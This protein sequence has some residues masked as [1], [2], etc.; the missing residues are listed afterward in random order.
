[1]DS[2][3]FA[4]TYAAAKKAREE[5]AFSNLP[6]GKYTASLA[7][8]FRNVSQQGQGRAQVCLV[9]KILE[10]EEEGKEH[11]QYFG[12]ENQIS[13]E[14]LDSTLQRMGLDTEGM[15]LEVLDAILETL[16][17]KVPMVVLVLK[18]KGEYLNT[19]ISEFNGWTKSGEEEEE[20]QE[21]PRTKPPKAAAKV[22]DEPSLSE[23]ADSATADVGSKVKFKTDAGEKVGVIV[24]IDADSSVADLKMGL[25]IYKDVSCENILEIVS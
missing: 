16:K 11:R 8:A 20:V 3:S 1:M 19:N 4:A 21:A 13:L 15:S 22:E 9:W 24:K 17:A 10:G 14:I 12:L 7:D 23:D 25:K 5:K 2:K 18:Q 6:P